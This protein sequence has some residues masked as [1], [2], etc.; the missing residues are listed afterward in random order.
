MCGITFTCIICNNTVYEPAY[1]GDNIC[2]RCANKFWSMI[3]GYIRYDFRA[4]KRIS[5]RKILWQYL[6]IRGKI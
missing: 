6:K 1:E 4:I 2:N 3:Y 5:S